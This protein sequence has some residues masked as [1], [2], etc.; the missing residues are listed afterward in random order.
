MSQQRSKN[1]GVAEVA[2]GLRRVRFRRSD[3]LRAPLLSAS[4]ECSHVQPPQVTEIPLLMPKMHR[5]FQVP[6]CSCCC[7]LVRS[8]DQ[9]RFTVPFVFDLRLSPPSRRAR[10]RP[11]SRRVTPPPAPTT[12]L[13]DAVPLRH[14]RRS[15]PQPRC[16]SGAA[17]RGAA[18]RSTWRPA[19]P[20]CRGTRRELTHHHP[21]ALPLPPRFDVVDAA[22]CSAHAPPDERLQGGGQREEVRPPP[23]SPPRCN[24]QVRRP[25]IRAG[26]ARRM[27]W[28]FFRLA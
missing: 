27:G 1:V 24:F 28:G 17:R 6:A 16:E 20:K 14:V 3:V 10:P 21:R 18:P 11:S 15:R 8:S 7:W 25:S 9:L 22:P 19:R 23:A 13:E 26:F 4:T 5:T 12:R 2:R